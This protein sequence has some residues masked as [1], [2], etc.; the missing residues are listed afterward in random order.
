MTDLYFIAA[1]GLLITA[2]ILLIILLMRV[3][4][5]GGE[6]VAGN[7]KGLQEIQERTDHTI[8]D[9]TAKSRD[10]MGKAARD[11]RL[12]LTETV[13]NFGDSIAQRTIE[14]AN[15][16]KGQL[17]IFSNQLSSFSKSSAERLDAIEDH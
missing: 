11:Q 8:R 16:Q 7:L 15:L 17:E 13:K 3:S 1:F 2:V 10:E 6:M 4:R 5:A 12:E 14:V 9:E